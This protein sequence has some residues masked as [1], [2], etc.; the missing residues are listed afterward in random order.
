MPV[1]TVDGPALQVDKKRTLVRQLTD[2]AVSVYDIKHIVVLIKEN[3]P[4]NV[5]VD[6]ELVAD[7]NRG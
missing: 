6:G 2:V 1:I 3:D 7:R 4:E 5:G